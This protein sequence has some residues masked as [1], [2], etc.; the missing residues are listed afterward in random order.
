MGSNKYEGRL[1]IFHNYEWGT[2]CDYSFADVDGEVVC[3]QL[4]LDFDRILTNTDE[5]FG[6]IRYDRQ[7]WMDDIGCTGNEHN[8]AA[9]DFSGWGVHV[10]NCDHHQDIHMRCKGVI[11][12]FETHVGSTIA[13]E[14][15][16]YRVDF[17]EDKPWLIFESCGSNYHT[18]LYFYD[19]N[20]NEIKSCHD[21]ND[22][23]KE[24]GTS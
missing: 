14:I 7:I 12:P 4:G 19:S 16:Y 13:N 5:R 17:T 21:C 23:G 11:N 10:H 8:L 6:L 15:I 1:E 22:F 24:C 18:Y 9:C 3:N 2:I 20:M